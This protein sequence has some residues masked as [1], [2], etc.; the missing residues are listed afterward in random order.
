MHTFC[1]SCPICGVGFSSTK[2]SRKYCSRDCANAARRGVPS[3]IAGAYHPSFS[4]G[5]SGSPEYKTWTAV[6]QR[7][8][9]SQDKS[10]KDYGAKGISVC[11]SWRESF[12]S[13]LADMGPRPSRK[14]SIDRYPNQNGNYEPRNCR[15]ATSTEQNRNKRTNHLI[16]SNGV[17]LCISEWS[18]KTGI[19]VHAIRKRLRIG[20]SPETA[21]SIP[22]GQLSQSGRGRPF[23]SHC[24]NGHP[25]C[26]GNIYVRGNQRKCVQCRREYDRKTY[27]SRQALSHSR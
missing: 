11:D 16:A 18:E 17:T 27:S 10:Y 7:C 3:E 12:E 23:Q 2:K 1:F 25:L 19:S 26:D 9:N 14:H 6:I 15:W 8:H 20:W 5:M 24:K 22:V 4:H 13:F 21:V